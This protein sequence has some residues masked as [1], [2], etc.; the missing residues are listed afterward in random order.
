MVPILLEIWEFE[1]C[2]HFKISLHNITSFQEK[3]SLVFIGLSVYKSPVLREFYHK[4]SLKDA[5]FFFLFSDLCDECGLT[6]V[7]EKETNVQ[8]PEHT[9]NAGLIFIPITHVRYLSISRL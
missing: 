3:R 6:F 7:I 2:R 4:S 8:A 1:N 5:D 9:R